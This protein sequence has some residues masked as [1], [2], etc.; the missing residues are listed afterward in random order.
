MLQHNYKDVPH[1]QSIAAIPQMLGNAIFIDEVGADKDNAQYDAYRYYECGLRIG[2]EDYTVRITIG[3]KRGKYY[4]DH[5]LTEIEKG[6][7][8]NRAE[9]SSTVAESKTPMSDIK[10][11]RLIPILQT[12]SSK[13]VDANGEPTV[14]EDKQGNPINEDGTLKV[15]KVESIDAITD[16][17]FIEPYR[18]IELPLLPERVSNAI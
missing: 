16:E 12:N 13:I 8:L 7:L 4:Y 5:S 17:N 1:I 11:K 10:D 14:G 18:N 9:L 6:E 15:E 2:N 3:V